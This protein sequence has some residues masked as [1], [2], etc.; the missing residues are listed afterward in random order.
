[1]S[2][3]SVST[4]DIDLLDFPP[5]RS[6]S[7]TSMALPSPMDPSSAVSG[8]DDETASST[9]LTSH[10]DNEDN[11]ESAMSGV[12]FVDAD[13]AIDSFLPLLQALDS[14][15]LQLIDGKYHLRGFI[16]KDSFKKLFDYAR[17][18]TKFT[19]NDA[20]SLVE[21]GT[22]LRLVQLGARYNKS[23]T[24]FPS[25]KSLH[26]DVNKPETSLS[27]LPLFLLH[28]LEVLEVEQHI[29]ESQFDTF[30]TFLD[31]LA[32]EA[33]HLSSIRLG[34]GVSYDALH[35][36]CMRFVNLR[37]LKLSIVGSVVSWSMLQDLGQLPEL[38]IL[39]LD[40]RAA[41]YRSF[42][43]DCL[44][45]PS[46]PL[47]LFGN[48]VETLP[49][50]GSGDDGWGAPYES[51][52]ANDNFGVHHPNDPFLEAPPSRSPSPSPSIL[53]ANA[54]EKLK[55]P[56]HAIE[57][58]EPIPYSP[59]GG[60]YKLTTLHIVAKLD[61]MSTL[62]DMIES[63]KL[64]D[65]SLT[66]TKLLRRKK[67]TG[68][69][70][71]MMM[72]KP[73]FEAVLRTVL[74]SWAHSLATVRICY[75]KASPDDPHA[76]L[77]LSAFQSLLSLP[78]LRHLEISGLTMSLDFGDALHHLS[79]LTQPSGLETLH[80]PIDLGAKGISL[81][82][83][84][85]ILESCPSLTSFQCGFKHL[86]NVPFLP[87]DDVTFGVKKLAVGN[88]VAHDNRRR[89]MEVAQ[90]LDALFPKL[91]SIE[92]QEGCNAGQW[93]EIHELVQM[94]QLSRSHHRK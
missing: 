37:E 36:T 6:Q 34:T 79:T 82:R 24:F 50:A 92:T 57:T 11:I 65:I 91:E 84:R 61:L 15:G 51:K 17:R 66:S 63:S 1:M 35:S 33:P 74:A 62:M 8:P 20:H 93:Q 43:E 30:L 31:T 40:A 18:V 4:D 73:K 69:G 39:V 90:Y 67:G 38:E 45:S 12:P 81:S 60:F 3:F 26:I 52:A 77:E 53:A 49:P 72:L 7:P 41:S 44:P 42:E 55:P 48:T 58:V 64:V 23:D 68:P 9:I 47:S 80:L 94:C 14:P 54:L 28:T 27:L 13:V 71:K 25:L 87:E 21:A 19:L 75:Q 5:S 88:P 32:D 56:T 16:S 83:L 78:H 10:E 70:S 46:P 86:S 59:K 2:D 76:E 22:L 89:L 29:P 85:G